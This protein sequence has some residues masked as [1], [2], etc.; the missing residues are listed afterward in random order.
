MKNIKMLIVVALVLGLVGFAMAKTDK[1]DPSPPSGDHF[2]VNCVTAWSGFEGTLTI[3]SDNDPLTPPDWPTTGA[4]TGDLNMSFNDSTGVLTDGDGTLLLTDTG[5]NTFT[6]DSGTGKYEGWLIVGTFSGP[7]TVDNL[8]G[9]DTDTYIL[10]GHIEKPNE[11]L[12]PYDGSGMI[13]MVEGAEFEITDNDM[14]DGQA[15]IQMPAGTY[16]WWDQARGKPGGSMTWGDLHI[17]A[18]KKPVWELHPDGPGS[19]GD[20]FVVPTDLGNWPYT[21]DGCTNYALRL[22]PVVVPE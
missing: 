16:D 3:T 4:L 5:G 8:D 10:T 1:H 20:D 6:M 18:T 19:A 22:Y 14:T 13:G 15:W 21:N 9:T 2:N 7:V 17:R 11:I 12:V